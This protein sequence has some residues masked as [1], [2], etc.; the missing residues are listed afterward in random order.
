MTTSPATLALQ[1]PIDQLH[2]SDEEHQ[3]NV[4]ARGLPVNIAAS[5]QLPLQPAKIDTIGCFLSSSPPTSST[6]ISPNNKSSFDGSNTAADQRKTL[7]HLRA[8][9]SRRSG[10]ARL[11][12]SGSSGSSCASPDGAPQQASTMVSMR[13]KTARVH[14]PMCLS[15]LLQTQHA[16]S[17]SAPEP[18]SPSHFPPTPSDPEQARMNSLHKLRRHLSV[19]VPPEL[20]LKNPALPAAP[21]APSAANIRRLEKLRRRLSGSVPPHLVL[22][23]TPRYS[24]A[25]EEEGEEAQTEV[26][27]EGESR[28]SSSELEGESLSNAQHKSHEHVVIPSSDCKGKGTPFG[29]ACLQDLCVSSAGRPAVLPAPAPTCH[30]LSTS[31]A[32]FVPVTIERSGRR[33]RATYNTVVNA[34]RALR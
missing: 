30:L 21:A 23:V 18:P 2:S 9:S 3:L 31:T 34:L 24:V 22:P 1:W 27:T 13:T 8:P 29:D 33:Y 11:S 20:V 28:R 25:S 16:R 10:S 12:S 17:Q 14:I 6:A 7:P 26:Q 19:S 15:M 4:D 32:N 5:P